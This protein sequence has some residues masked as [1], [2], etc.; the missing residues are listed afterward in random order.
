MKNALSR[1]A[2]AH[3]VFSLIANQVIKGTK[4]GGCAGAHR[5]DDLF[6]WAVRTFL[7]AATLCLLCLF[8]K[9]IIG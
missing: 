7:G 3:F 2:I 6:V 9:T 1:F 4:G 8:F 5:N